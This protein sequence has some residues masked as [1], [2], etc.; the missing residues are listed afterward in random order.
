MSMHKSATMLLLAASLYGCNGMPTISQSDSYFTI[1]SIGGYMASATQWNGE[2]AVTVKH[3]PFRSYE[4]ACSTGCDMVFFK[5]KSLKP[6]S[7]RQGI[8][9][10][11]ISVYGRGLT[12]TTLKGEGKL[13]STPFLNTEEG[14]KELYRIHDAPL[15]KGMSGGSV[16]ANSDGKVVG[17]NVGIYSTTLHSLSGHAEMK[18]AKR[19]S[20]FVPYSTIQREWD[21]FKGEM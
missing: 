16:V 10:E 1:F 18:D 2:Y 12:L 7:W 21:K 11:S 5:H 9:G 4:Y 6:P 14:S 17:I 13:Y 3:T 8:T 20:I 19:V 15:A